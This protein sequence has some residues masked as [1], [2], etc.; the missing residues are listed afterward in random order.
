M[1]FNLW[2][3]DLLLIHKKQQDF[4][5]LK[6]DESFYLSQLCSIV[7]DNWVMVFLLKIN[8]KPHFSG[9]ELLDHQISLW[10]SGKNI[11]MVKKILLTF[12]RPDLGWLFNHFNILPIFFDGL[13]ATAAPSKYEL[14]SSSLNNHCPKI[15]FS[16]AVH[17]GV[18]PK[19]MPIIFMWQ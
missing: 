17:V 1:S 11:H 6:K 15:T 18:V 12:A 8:R 19:K 13:P 9:K 14:V 4:L 7:L 10:I 3:K 2:S 16:N 5:G